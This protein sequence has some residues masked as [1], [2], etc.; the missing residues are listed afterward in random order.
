MRGGPVVIGFDGTSASE[1]AIREAG[2]LLRGHQALVVVVWKRGIGFEAMTVPVGPIGLE[3]PIIDIAAAAE[4]D[5]A[6]FERAQ[7]L[8]QRGAQI[9][10]EAGLKAEPLAAA[11]ELH[12]PVGETIVRLARDRDAEAIVVGAHNHGR[13]SE[14]LLGSTSRDVVRH[15]DRPVVV[16]REAG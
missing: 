16:V 4:I 11:D 15:A 13:L 1:Q 7:K 14:V 10:V 9:A 2:D 8:A 12:V 5:K 3:P 6:M